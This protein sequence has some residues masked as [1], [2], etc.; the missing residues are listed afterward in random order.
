M[1]WILFSGDYLH[2]EELRSVRASQLSFEKSII[3]GDFW[4][5]NFSLKKS[6]ESMVANSHVAYVRKVFKFTCMVRR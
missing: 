5:Q 3:P 4:K 6:S 1:Q 2:F